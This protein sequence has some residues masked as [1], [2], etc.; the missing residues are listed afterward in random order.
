MSLFPIVHDFKNDAVSAERY[1]FAMAR[2]GWAA[3][4]K[5]PA[6]GSWQVHINGF[7]GVEAVTSSLQDEQ[8]HN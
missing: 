5:R 2:G 7:R 3:K 4:V 6:G 8:A 1:C